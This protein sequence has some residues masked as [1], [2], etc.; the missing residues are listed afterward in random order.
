MVQTDSAVINNGFQK[1][2]KYKI[3]AKDLGNMTKTNIDKK[4]LQS[5]YMEGSCTQ[6]EIA[7]K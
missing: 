2:I 6:E 7:A 4:A 5:L 3:F 1:S